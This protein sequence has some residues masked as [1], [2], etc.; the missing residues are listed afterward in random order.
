MKKKSESDGGSRFKLAARGRQGLKSHMLVGSMCAGTWRL[1]SVAAPRY[2]YDPERKWQDEKRTREKPW[3][4]AVK[5]LGQ[6]S[7][8]THSR[9]SACK[10]CASLTC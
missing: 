9:D 10:D 8:A 4:N 3:K 6:S 5:T 1:E 2:L 7:W